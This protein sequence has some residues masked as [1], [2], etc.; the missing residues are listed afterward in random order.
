MKTVSPEV[1]IY[2]RVEKKKWV[3]LQLYKLFS[4][5]ELLLEAGLGLI[6]PLKLHSWMHFFWPIRILVDFTSNEFFGSEV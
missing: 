3:N 4:E 5:A 1:E 6:K 2:Y